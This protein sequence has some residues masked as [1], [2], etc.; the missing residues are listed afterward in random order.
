MKIVIILCGA[1]AVFLLVTA[2]WG[3]FGAEL[4]KGYARAQ[5]AANE[6]LRAASIYTMT[7]QRL[8]QLRGF[9]ALGGALV[10]MLFTGHLIIAL[11]CAVIG[12]LLPKWWVERQQ[13]QRLQKL[14]E[15]LPAAL[16]QLTGSV[17]AGMSLPQALDE[18][19]R[20][21]PDPMNL[22]FGIISRE[23][24][25]GARLS[26]S[27]ISAQHRIG[28][29]F[30]PLFGTA[31][32]MNVERGGNLPEAMQ[33]MSES[34]R[35]IWR[36]EQKAITASAEA[37]KAM[38]VIG[39]MPLIVGLMVFIT[40]PDIID[41]LTGSFPGWLVLAAVAIFYTIGIMWLKKLMS[42]EA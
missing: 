21:G 38:R 31:L 7:G 4:R 2:L 3:T 12:A 40:Q 28:G 29:R 26:D 9:G 17:R 34:F 6:Q 23:T 35:E 1:A 25:M 13:I 37:R 27:I 36:L 19:S 24:R 20:T 8:V 30:F 14:E 22:E 11:V 10:G 41:T 18:V 33:R 32:R 42:A 39:A 16:D 5:G 15:V